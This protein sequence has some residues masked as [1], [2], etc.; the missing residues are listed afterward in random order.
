M[1]WKDD[2]DELNRQVEMA[3]QMGGHDSVAFHHGR[4]KLT[5]RERIALLE[6]PGTFQEIGAIAGTATWDGDQVTGLKPSNTIIGTCLIDGRKIAFS[7]GDFTIRGGASD[8]AIGNKSQYA[9][10]YA[11]DTRVPYFRL[12]DATGDRDKTC[13]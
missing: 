13:S 1:S 9:E 10:Q 12:L 7:G 4:G 11:L 5:V 6:D 3:G 2:V 8:A